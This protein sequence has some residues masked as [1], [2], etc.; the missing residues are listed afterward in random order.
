VT[1]YYTQHILHNIQQDQHWTMVG[2]FTAHL[3]LRP[4]YAL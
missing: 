2:N 4:Y 3:K 1:K